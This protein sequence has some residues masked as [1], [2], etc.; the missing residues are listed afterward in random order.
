MNFSL[1]TIQ[2]LLALT[3]LTAGL[4]KLTRP[5][6][7]LAAQMRWVE[8]FGDGQVKTIAA[9]EVLAAIGLI[10]PGVL[11]VATILTPLAAAGL[12]ALMIGAAITHARRGE[13]PMIGLNLVL[14]AMAAFVAW[15]RFGPDP[16]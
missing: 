10:V 15:G 13:S 9:L 5:R 14:L 12:I 8:D 3:F 11:H 16:L 1:W 7:A 6:S 2:G 4:I